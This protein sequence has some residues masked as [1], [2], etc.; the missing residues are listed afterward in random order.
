MSIVISFIFQEV[1]TLAIAA[2]TLNDQMSLINFLGLVLCIGG[3]VCHAVYK[4]RKAKRRYYLEIEGIDNTA[5]NVDFDSE[6]STTSKN[7]S[8]LNLCNP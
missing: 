6:D 7:A 2:L 8:Y 4:Y 3:V 1:A 5:K